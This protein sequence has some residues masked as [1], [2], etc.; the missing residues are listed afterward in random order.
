MW[1]IRNLYAEGDWYGDDGKPMR[2]RTRAE[3]QVYKCK[4]LVCLLCDYGM[5]FDDDESHVCKVKE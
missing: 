5:E 2:F 3:A 1:T 4:E